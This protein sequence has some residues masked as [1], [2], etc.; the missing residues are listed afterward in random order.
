MVGSR[1]KWRICALESPLNRDESIYL[2][3]VQ[4]YRVGTLQKH[5]TGSSFRY[6]ITFRYT[7]EGGPRAS[8]VLCKSF[9][10]NNKTRKSFG[11]GTR[12]TRCLKEPQRNTRQQ[13]VFVNVF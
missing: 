6:A 5:R 10:Y 13:A 8:H 2:P 7:P 3:S 1:E 12:S 11:S 9:P 4:K